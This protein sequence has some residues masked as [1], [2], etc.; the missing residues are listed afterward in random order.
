[1]SV[2]K[3]PLQRALR[4]DVRILA[5]GIGERNLRDAK[6]RHALAAAREYIATELRLAGYAVRRQ[7][8]LVDEVRVQNLEI[9]IVGRH[10]PEEIVVVGAHYDSARETPGANDNATGVAALLAV[11][12]NLTTALQRTVRFVAFCTEEQPHTRTPSMGS[13]VYARECRRRGEAVTAMMS[14][15]TIG[16]YVRSHKSPDAPFPLDIASPWRHDFLAV[17]GNLA[18]RALAR[19]VARA[20][21][22]P[23]LRSKAFAL[24]GMLPGVRSSDHWSF[25]KEG[26]PAVM[27]TDTAWLRSRHYHRP[28]D[29]PSHVD[30]AGFAEATSGIARAVKALSLA[31]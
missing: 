22:S 11:A 16:A 4:D 15:E 18:S 28:T 27:V 17:F 6:R 14:L 19:R 20:V 25:W 9:E 12:R 21:A 1:V 30:F 26:Y 29:V 5:H 8:Y 3:S 31:A 23:T 10:R 13:R 24:P 2:S 7:E